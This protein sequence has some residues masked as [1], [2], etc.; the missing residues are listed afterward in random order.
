MEYNKFDF[1]K[2]AKI[3]LAFTDIFLYTVTAGNKDFP[4][5][6]LRIVLV[7]NARSKKK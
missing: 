6:N 7:G 2:F 3:S 5:Y 4:F 1:L